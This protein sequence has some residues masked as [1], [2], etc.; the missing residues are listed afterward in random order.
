MTSQA[1]SKNIFNFSKEFENQDT[2][3]E[4]Q[5]KQ[6]NLQDFPSP[7]DVDLTK[8]QQKEIAS[9]NKT[10]CPDNILNDTPVTN[11]RTMAF[12]HMADKTQ[13]AKL[14][15]CTKACRNI[16]K[17]PQTGEFGVCSR[18][19]CTFAHSMNELQPARCS[20]D[21]TCRFKHGRITD[22]KTKNI[23][24]DSKCKFRHSDESIQEYYSRS[25]MTQPELPLTSEHTRKIPTDTDEPNKNKTAPEPVPKYNA[26]LNHKKKVSF[27][28]VPKY[29]AELNHK[30]KVY[31]PDM[32][33]DSESEDSEIE[34]DSRQI[35]KKERKSKSPKSAMQVIRVPTKELAEIALKALFDR[36]QFN[37]QVLIE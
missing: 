2:S 26:E 37:V 10:S 36:G 27:E 25:G 4:K 3:V 24:H 34:E 32:S 17:D 23:A 20:F 12:N 8:K 14:L 5:I 6:I 21:R 22:W 29:N 15:T 1:I 28:P 11:R 9:S 31:E 19:Y 16:Q 33:S 18:K 35:L 7:G 30:K 13:V